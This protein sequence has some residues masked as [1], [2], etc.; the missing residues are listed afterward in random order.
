[1]RALWGRSGPWLFD[2]RKDVHAPPL[3]GPPV[4]VELHNRFALVLK[5]SVP[6]VVRLAQRLMVVRINEQ[7]PTAIVWLTMVNHRSRLYCL[8]D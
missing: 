5:L 3:K 1:M 6:V 8:T 7:L 2:C 4:G